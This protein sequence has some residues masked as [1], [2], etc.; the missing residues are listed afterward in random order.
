MGRAMTTNDA[1]ETTDSA[2][3][4]LVPPPG[5]GLV[6]VSCRIPGDVRLLSG[7]VAV[8]SVGDRYVVGTAAPPIVT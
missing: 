8:S 5:D 1:T 3:S 7:R 2:A 4:L 6:T